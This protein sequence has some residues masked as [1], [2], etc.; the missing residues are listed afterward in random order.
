MTSNE[1]D[2]ILECLAQNKHANPVYGHLISVATTML[3]W[4]I[5]CERNSRLFNNIQM[6]AD[7]R[8]ISIIQECKDITTQGNTD[9]SNIKG[10]E[11]IIAE[12][13][14][15]LDPNPEWMNHHQRPR[16][17]LNPPSLAAGG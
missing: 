16:S 11:F 13:S 14:I 4:N 7:I 17:D 9:N 2:Q 1:L 5:W 3:I 10:K 6:P 8:L 12:F 15:N